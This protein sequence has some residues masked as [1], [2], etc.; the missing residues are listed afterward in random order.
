[1]MRMID[2][3]L[4]RILAGANRARWLLRVCVN[5]SEEYGLLSLMELCPGYQ[6]GTIEL[7]WF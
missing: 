1:M 4:V 5:S 2:Y 3:S 6:P 7:G